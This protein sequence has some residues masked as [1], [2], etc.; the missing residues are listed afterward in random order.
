MQYELEINGRVRQV[1][2]SREG[3]SFTV[4]VDGHTFTVDAARVDNYMLSLLI[5]HRNG[6]TTVPVSQEVTVSP[7]AAT[8]QL[9]VRV[10]P[11][12]VL[13]GMNTRR[14][15]GQAAEAGASGSGPQRVTAPMPGKI[16]RIL[17]KP[18]ETVHPRQPLIVVEAM[19]MENELR[20]IREGTVAEV[21]V[22]VGASVEAGALLV[23]VQ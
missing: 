21:H 20:A 4:A 19:K 23:V 11:M 13:V 16:V 5:D 7:D 9:A 2:V 22:R 17:V 10:G 8:K 6:S 1:N 14:R 12:R 18:G 15:W 3:G